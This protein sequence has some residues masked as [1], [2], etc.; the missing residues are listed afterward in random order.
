MAS[1]LTAIQQAEAESRTRRAAIENGAR[2]ILG[3]WG[4]VI[5]T[6]RGVIP[7]SIV[8][9]RAQI[10][11][12]GNPKAGPT[13]QGERGLLMLW[14]ATQT[15]YGVKDPTDPK[16]NLRGG[17]LHWRNQLNNM[18]KALPGYLSERNRDFWTITQL[19]TM[20][21]GGA[22]KALLTAAKVQPGREYQDLVAWLKRTGESLENYRGNFGTQS[23]ATVARRIIYAGFMTDVA[24]SIG[25]LTSALPWLVVL[26]GG[27]W[28]IWKR[29]FKGRG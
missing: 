6:Y 10:E 12:A 9:V 18:L 16:E 11:S 15:T 8:A 13:A 14:P 28:L 20:I 19:Y 4:A 17:L 26:V 22:T 21:G 2:T 23:A 5:D 24:A 7:A 27:G 25:G 3:K 29:Y 1:V